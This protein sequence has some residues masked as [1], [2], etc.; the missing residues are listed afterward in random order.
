MW[1]LSF[2]TAGPR[3]HRESCPPQGR[4]PHARV[5]CQP[6]RVSPI[7]ARDQTS[8]A[9]T[10]PPKTSIWKGMLSG[11]YFSHTPWRLC[12][13]LKGAFPPG[14]RL[15][16]AAGAW[17]LQPRRHQGGPQTSHPTQLC[18]THSA[19]IWGAAGVGPARLWVQRPAAWL[20]PPGSLGEIQAPSLTEAGG[21]SG[22]RPPSSLRHLPAA[23]ASVSLPV[24]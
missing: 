16:P 24:G 21:V 3:P 2:P 15:P 18:S 23:L 10:L 17:E 1:R 7:A 8:P 6:G 22:C 19:S 13:I 20:C 12:Q 9:K 5:L 11:C 4:E 14:G